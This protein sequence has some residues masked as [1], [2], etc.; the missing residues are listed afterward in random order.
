[1]FTKGKVVNVRM[2]PEAH[3]N[4]LGFETSNGIPSCIQAGTTLHVMNYLDDLLVPGTERYQNMQFVCESFPSFL[5]CMQ[6]I[7]FCLQNAF[8]PS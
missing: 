1:M 5:I 2:A 4:I 7:L 8:L 3:R 6:N